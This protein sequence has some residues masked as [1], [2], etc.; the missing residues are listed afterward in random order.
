MGRECVADIWN[1]G[2]SYILVPVHVS[3]ETKVDHTA[4][5]LISRELMP[6]AVSLRDT[7]RLLYSKEILGL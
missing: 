6:G 3:V 2:H 5:N 1:K 7:T 4:R